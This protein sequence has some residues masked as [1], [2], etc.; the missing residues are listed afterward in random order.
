[1]L[2]RKKKKTIST[3]ITDKP[4]DVKQILDEQIEASLHEFNRSNSGLLISSFA[5]GMEV[6]FSVLLMGTM[7][8]MFSESI[9]PEMLH[10]V[11]SFCYP[12][13][14]IFV[15]IGRSELFTEHTALAVLPV[16]N[17]SVS[18]KS[19]LTLW[20][21]VYVG[22]LLGGYLFSFL[23]SQIGMMNGFIYDEAFLHLATE[24]THH[25]W[26]NIL[27]SGMVAG[28]MMGLLG[29]LLTSSQET[30][31]RIFVIILVTSTIG[32]A[33]LHHCIVGSIEVFSGMLVHQAVQLSDYLHFL[34]WATLG[35]I[36]GG[37]VFVAL[38]KY[39]HIRMSR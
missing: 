5:G 8:T 22:N 38:L 14:F 2:F 24:L 36:L 23:I 4:K 37:V 13:G 15:I 7:F 1:M 12:I 27:L 3:H 29:W 35:N 34:V 25:H 20:G 30:I 26:Y 10:I 32:I 28:W 18:I 11:L 33:G 21:L 16:F 39:G 31:S 9:S 6:G 17:G 19:L